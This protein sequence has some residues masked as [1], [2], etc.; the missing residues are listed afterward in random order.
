[1][2]PLDAEDMTV[3]A[4]KETLLAHYRATG[5]WLT[6]IENDGKEGKQGSYGLE[7]GPYMGMTAKAFTSRI[8]SGT[9]GLPEGLTLRRLNEEVRLAHNLPLANMR[10]LDAEEMTV[11]GVKETLQAHYHATGRWLTG[12]EKDGEDG[13]RGSYGLEHGPYKGMTVAAFKASINN[14]SHCLPEGLTLRGVNEEVRLEH[15]LPL[16]NMYRLRSKD[17]GRPAGADESLAHMTLG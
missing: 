6:G 11:G 17:E 2:H 14:G 7:H 4:V 8:N 5:R 3:G 13:K 1:M 9:H 12:D 16:A 15:R 10:P